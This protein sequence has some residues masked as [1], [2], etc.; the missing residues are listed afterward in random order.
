M[1]ELAEPKKADGGWL[2]L[3]QHLLTL[4]T[5]YNGASL[6]LARIESV[7]LAGP[8]VFARSARGETHAIDARF[9]RT[10]PSTKT[11]DAEK[12]G[13]PAAAGGAIGALLG[14]GKGAAAGAAI[15]GG[16]GTALVLTTPGKNIELPSGTMLSL[17]I[18]EAIDVRVPVRPGDPDKRQIQ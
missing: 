13:I 12:I 15:G 7:K 11:K 8:L 9:A 18:G 16:A 6:G 5:A 17:A 14:G 2:E 4:H 3:G 10:A 1:L